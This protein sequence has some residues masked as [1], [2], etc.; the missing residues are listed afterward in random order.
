MRLDD[1]I[2]TTKILYN[3]RNS[4]SNFNLPYAP[5]VRLINTMYN[6]NAINSRH[7]RITRCTYFFLFFFKDKK[8][9]RMPTRQLL[10]NDRV[11]NSNGFGGGAGLPNKIVPHLRLRSD[12]TFFRSIFAK[13]LFIYI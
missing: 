1:A 3:Y 9:V 12:E 13:S 2:K 5:Y 7:L 4:N 11:I 8:T 10:H 6:G